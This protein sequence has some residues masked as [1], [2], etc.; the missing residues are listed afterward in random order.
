VVSALSGFTGFPGKWGLGWL[1]WSSVVIS[2]MSGTWSHIT[3]LGRILNPVYT[4]TGVTT[5]RR[6][7]TGTRSRVEKET[8]IMIR[9]CAA[10]TRSINDNSAW[11]GFA[12]QHNRCRD[13]NTPTYCVKS[14]PRPAATDR[15]LTCTSR[16][17]RTTRVLDHPAACVA[18]FEC[19]TC[20]PDRW[21]YLR[22][23]GGAEKSDQAPVTTPFLRLFPGLRP[24]WHLTKVLCLK[25]RYTTKNA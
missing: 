25:Y 11:L 1:I 13:M 17:H 4:S 23:V 14:S 18:P 8:Y 5:W 6:I 22:L 16:H 7:S 12:W 21:V 2:S 20:A 9:L 15:Y 3:P 10:H 19:C 24:C